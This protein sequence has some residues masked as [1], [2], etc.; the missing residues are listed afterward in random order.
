[1]STATPARGPGFLDDGSRP[2][3]GL[4]AAF[5]SLYRSHR[6][7]VLRLCRAMVGHPQDAEE[8]AQAT[9]LSAYRALERGDRPDVAGAWLSTIA[10]N[11]CRDLI[12]RRKLE[13]PLPEGL[14]AVTSDPADTVERRERIRELRRD[15]EELPSGQRTALVLR[16]MGGL[17]HS[18]IAEVVGGSEQAARSLVHEARES[19]AEFEEGRALGCADVRPRIDSSDGRALRARR[20]RAH[21][22]VC[23]GCREAAGRRRG[24]RIAGWLPVPAFWAAL[25]AL[26]TGGTA[27]PVAGGAALVSMVAA[28]AL[29]IPGPWNPS[30]APADGGPAG[31]PRAGSAAPSWWTDAATTAGGSA[32]GTAGAPR[33]VT[34]PPPAPAPGAAPGSPAPAPAASAAPATAP[35]AGE[36]A[37]GSAP[38][39][40]APVARV[41][42]RTG[43]AA[44]TGLSVT[45][46]GAGAT[47]GGSGVDVDVAGVGVSAGSGG[48]Q[49]TSPVAGAGVQPPATG[50]VPVV[51]ATVDAVRL[52]SVEVPSAT[53]PSMGTPLGATPQ[54]TTPA[55]T[56][57]SRVATPPLAG[58]AGPPVT[59]DLEG[60]P[61]IAIGS[62]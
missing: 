12:A 23:D 54:V 34:R 58:G 48:V 41:R 3:E 50:V 57:P 1:M 47:V 21:I 20:V 6:E 46:P 42:A 49:V 51:D 2:V 36:P 7:R 30:S 39:G 17:R 26:F 37:A 16:S 18:E 31:A 19:L 44:G 43:G 28:G 24:G 5:E 61:R 13:V 11:E 15:L 4:E 33:A 25:R 59:A 38:S 32:A 60:T 10:R 9:M 45:A 52:P 40:Q 56:V 29:V 62:R 55:G 14:P 8:A 35:A 27:V 53:V 22:R